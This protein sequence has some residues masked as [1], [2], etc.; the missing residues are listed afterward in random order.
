MTPSQI[1]DM[2][3]KMDEVRNVFVMSQ[4]SL[5]F[6]EELFRFLKEISPTLD[7]INRYIE[8]TAR[9]MPRATTQLQSVSEANRLATTE[10]LDM[11]DIVIARIEEIRALVEQGARLDTAL[12]DADDRILLLLREQLQ[13]SHAVLLA[14]VEQLLLRKD[15]IRKKRIA[16]SEPLFDGLNEIRDRANRIMLS[17]QVQDITAQQITAV[18]HLIESI[19]SR[20]HLLVSR[21]NPAGYDGTVEPETAAVSTTFDPDASYD[22]T[23]DRQSMV[24]AIFEGQADALPEENVSMAKSA[25]TE[26]DAL[27]SPLSGRMSLSDSK[28]DLTGV[29]ESGGD[30]YEGTVA[31]LSRNAPSPPNSEKASQDEIDRL[32]NG[33]Q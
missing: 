10:I 19:R 8:E 28:N 27:P 15:A 7:E 17:L 5:P 20:M 29:P 9:K 32:F 12:A 6:L 18:N 4:R 2:L 14:D 1:N 21:I 22:H 3:G 16:L 11:V 33:K 24:D 23:P 31:H 26:N 25:R 30:G 13:D